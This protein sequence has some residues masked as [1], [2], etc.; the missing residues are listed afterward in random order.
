MSDAIL[1]L[2]AGASRIRFSLYGADARPGSDSLI[3]DGACAGIGD[4]MHFRARD[5]N[6][7]MLIDESLAIATTHEDAIAVLFGWLEGCFSE[8]RVVAVGHR[9]VHG[10]S[11]LTAPVRV[12]AAVL[13]EVRRLAPFARCDQPHNL[14]AVTAVAALFPGLEQ[15]AC[16]DT[17]F[18]RTI[19]DVAITYA[20]P[21]DLTTD[22]VR[23]YGFH[24]L[25]YESVV[26]ELTALFGSRV[27][28]ARV[29]VAHLQSEAASLCALFGGKSVATTTGFTAF[30]GLPTSHACG[31]L[32][33]GVVLYLIREKGL[34]VVQVAQLLQEES[35]LAGVAGI[36]DDVHALLAADTAPAREAIDLFVYRI[37]RELGSMAAALGGI[38]ALVFTGAIGEG[39]VEI[40]R[41][42]CE[43]ASWLGVDLDDQANRSGGPCITRPAGRT[44][45]WVVPAHEKRLI[46]QH[47]WESLRLAPQRSTR[48]ASDGAVLSASRER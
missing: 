34:S 3:C 2:D 17:A 12:D 9:I 11:L 13:A 15:I 39:S 48:S 42:V 40:R 43:N 4:R 26:G 23:R 10:G 25:A 35:G 20:L 29:V 31:A 16:F 46:A 47:V 37:E 1:V 14:A 27:A 6:G 5:S 28:D 38:D 30:D 32:D 18:H 41:R 21:R 22:G 45:A 44:S 8:S 7:A 36:S 33:P 19:P 24:G